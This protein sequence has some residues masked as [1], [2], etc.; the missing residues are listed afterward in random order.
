MGLHAGGGGRQHKEIDSTGRNVSLITAA[1]SRFASP[2][3][4]CPF[5]ADHVST[6]LSKTRE[7]VVAFALLHQSDICAS[8]AQSCASGAPVQSAVALK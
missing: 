7:F 1:N 8:E 2:L 5:R 6:E 3:R 4:V